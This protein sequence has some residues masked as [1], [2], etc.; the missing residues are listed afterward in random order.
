MR[1][2]I[3]ASTI[4][5]TSHNDRRL[6]C[7]SDIKGIVETEYRQWKKKRIEMTAW[8]N[9]AC[10]QRNNRPFQ[11]SII[12]IYCTSDRSDKKSRSILSPAHGSHSVQIW[13]TN[14]LSFFP[15]ISSISIHMKPE[16]EMKTER[17]ER[18]GEAGSS[19]CNLPIIVSNNNCLTPWD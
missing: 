6:G 16:K 14:M 7:V 4:G 1:L 19:I 11:A 5:K 2:K 8:Q 13:D 12:F 18:E 9:Q 17:W 10:M 15:T 3:K